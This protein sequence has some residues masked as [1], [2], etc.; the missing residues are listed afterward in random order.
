V[1]LF[2][3]ADRWLIEILVYTSKESDLPVIQN[4]ANV[5]ARYPNNTLTWKT[6]T[7]SVTLS[8]TSSITVS[9]EGDTGV[10]GV[11]DL[12]TYTFLV[13][14]TGV[15]NLSNIKLIDDGYREHHL[16]PQQNHL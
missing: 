4:T 8:A 5:T 3:I 9:K 11:G 6:D 14:N 1:G 2:G 7:H 12:V 10:A 16:L 13:K 15:T